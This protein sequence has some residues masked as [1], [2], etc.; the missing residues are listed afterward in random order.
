MESVRVMLSWR[1]SPLRN[2][3]GVVGRLGGPSGLRGPRVFYY[4]LFALGAFEGRRDAS[5]M[6]WVMEEVER[7]CSSFVFPCSTACRG[8]DVPSPRVW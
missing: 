7:S 4:C 2:R 6:A 8:F 3:H 5:S 1:V